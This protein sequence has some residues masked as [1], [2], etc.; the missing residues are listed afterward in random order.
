MEIRIFDDA[1]ERFIQSLEKPTIAKVLRT[2]DLL[3][4]FGQRLGMPH[5]KKVSERLF[6]LR[7]RGRQEVRIFYTFHKKSVILLC[8]FVKKSDK[9]P[10]KEIRIAV[11]KLQALDTI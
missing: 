1:L 4:M 11:N 3:E 10:R 8:G 9:T 6:E 5:T 2:I 7:I